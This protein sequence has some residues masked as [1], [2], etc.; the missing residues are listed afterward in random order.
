[1]YF[2]LNQWGSMKTW[3]LRSTRGGLN[4]LTNQALHFCHH[5]PLFAQAW[6]RLWLY[7]QCVQASRQA[8][9]TRWT[10]VYFNQPVVFSLQ[11][12]WR[13]WCL[14]EDEMDVNPFTSVG[15]YLTHENWPL[16]WPDFAAWPTLPCWPAHSRHTVACMHRFSHILSLSPEPAVWFM[17]EWRAVRIDHARKYAELSIISSSFEMATVVK[18]LILSLFV[19]SSRILKTHRMERWCKNFT[20]PMCLSQRCKINSKK[21]SLR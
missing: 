11:C 14:I 5:W 15:S 21:Q 4:P 16:N 3:G 7:S 2:W 19:H 1:M 6:T 13:S 8:V 10:W 12:V 18:G 17:S 9:V 20:I